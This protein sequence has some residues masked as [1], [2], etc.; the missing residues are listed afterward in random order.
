MSFLRALVYEIMYISSCGTGNERSLF[1]VGLLIYLYCNLLKV[2]LS[3][4]AH[5]L[6]FTS[7]VIIL[8]N[9]FFIHHNLYNIK[10]R[11]LVTFSCFISRMKQI[12]VMVM[13]L[14]SLFLMR[15][16]FLEGIWVLCC[17]E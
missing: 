7:H 11:N 10:L 15:K 4:F 9:K 14:L 16:N 17:L 3:L 5:L 1:V 6:F 2:M 13:I 8:C 12:S